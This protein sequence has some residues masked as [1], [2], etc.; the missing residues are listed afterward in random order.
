MKLNKKFALSGLTM[1]LGTAAF[2]QSYTPSIN[3]LG[4]IYNPP[5]DPS[6]TLCSNYKA[7]TADHK[8]EVCSQG[9]SMASWTAQKY[10][11]NAGKYLGCV[12]GYNQGFRIGYQAN[13][14]PTPQQLQQYMSTYANVNPISAVTLG[15]TEAQAHGE[16]VS[17]DDIIKRY[18]AVI[19]VKNNDGSQKLP[20]KSYNLPTITFTEQTDGFKTDL[21]ST[22]GDFSAV[23]SLGWVTDQTS[24]DQ[25]IAAQQIYALRQQGQDS[26]CSIASTVFDRRS[27]PAMTIWD[28]Y[29]QAYVA[30]QELDF[31]LYGWKNPDWAWDILTKDDL[32]LQQ[33]QTYNDIPTYTK[34]VAV[35]DTTTQTVFDPTTHLPVQDTNADGTPKV[36]AQGNPV[37]KTT[38]VPTG[39]S[40]I[41]NQPLSS[42]EQA[43]LRA[44]YRQAFNDAYSISY[45]RQYASLGYASSGQ[46]AMKLGQA[47]GTAVATSV[48][49][50]EAQKT[51]YNARYQTVAASAYAGQIKS[52]YIAS[53]N[54][55]L[56]IFQS[57]P[58]I[59]LSNSQI[60]GKDDLGGFRPGETVGLNFTATN[61]GEVARSSTLNFTGNQYLSILDQDGFQFTTPALTQKAYNSGWLAQITNGTSA[62]QTISTGYSVTEPGDLQDLA[63]FI[64]VS[65]SGQGDAQTTVHDF[66]E[67]DSVSGSID[68]TTGIVNLSVE[69]ENPLSKSPSDLDPALVFQVNADFGALGNTGMSA[70][71]VG[72][73]SHKT[74]PLSL[75]GLDPLTLIDAGSINGTVTSVLGTRTVHADPVR[76]AIADDKNTAYVNYFDALATGLSKNSGNQSM[77]DRTAHL[78]QSLAADVLGEVKSTN[79]LWKRDSGKRAFGDTLVSVITKRYALSQASGHMNGDAQRAYDMLANTIAHASMSSVRA[80]GG[81]RFSKNKNRKELLERLKKIS[82]SISANPKDFT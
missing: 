31:S 77:G 51:A 12:D 73:K 68:Y 42:D 22:Y 57:N 71:Q 13:D 78:A 35:S 25:M 40:H 56:N 66:A 30:Q 14:N 9:V 18:R 36:D 62:R 19:G 53:F 34:P 11:Q 39:T 15:Q 50:A 79:V 5:A 74:Y 61:L 10:A 29:R 54:H 20:D 7:N 38:Q 2:A 60:I 63:S 65:N 33:W 64:R 72:A 59:E 26:P 58:V 43:A 81:L 17:G 48:A 82:P 21:L 69:V 67:I 80:G 3:D 76:F 16:T 52:S 44:L 47:T 1:L 45:A 37:Y 24:F 75:G 32:T 70:I 41:E 4:T 46:A 8:Y 28:L 6:M 49:T 55:W 27:M 23:K